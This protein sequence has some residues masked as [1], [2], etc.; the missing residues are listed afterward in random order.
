M[1]P[2]LHRLRSSGS[3]QLGLLPEGTPASVVLWAAVPGLI[4]EL[5]ARQSDRLLD[6]RVNLP[7]T[8][9]F[10]LF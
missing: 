2:Q 4:S 8:A 7:E 1:V 5:R 3:E 10:A 9:C 6:F